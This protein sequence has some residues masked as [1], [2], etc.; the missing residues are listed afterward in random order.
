MKERRVNRCLVPRDVCRSEEWG[1]SMA[2]NTPLFQKTDWASWELQ[3]KLSHLAWTGV[4]CM[5][6]GWAGWENAG[7]KTVRTGHSH[8][9]TPEKARGSGDQSDTSAGGLGPHLD[10][11][12][13]TQGDPVRTGLFPRKLGVDLNNDKTIDRNRDPWLCPR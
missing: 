12:G 3:C 2:M 1:Q 13:P 7:S 6:G 4:V 10:R 8:S 9:V 5:V 11:E